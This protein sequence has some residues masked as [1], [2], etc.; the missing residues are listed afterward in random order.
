MT[1]DY[2]IV[3]KKIILLFVY[4]ANMCSSCFLTLNTLKISSDLGVFFLPTILQTIQLFEFCVWSID[5]WYKWFIFHKI[6]IKWCVVHMCT[7]KH[8]YCLFEPLSIWTVALSSG[9]IVSKHSSMARTRRVS[10]ST[11]SHCDRE[12]YLAT[13]KWTW[14]YKGCIGCIVQLYCITRL[15]P[16]VAVVHINR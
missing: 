10:Y 4:C 7:A 14:R 11:L 9:E 2:L 15:H 6:F 12:R 3:K 13:M 16:H 8:Y 1:T 5:G